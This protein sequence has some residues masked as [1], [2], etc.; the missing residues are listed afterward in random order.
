MKLR[1]VLIAILIVIPIIPSDAHPLDIS[2]TTLQVHPSCLMAT[3]YIHPYEL[4]LLAESQDLSLEK[5]SIPELR[6]VVLAYFNERFVIYSKKG[7]VYKES[8]V[9]EGG[10][11]Y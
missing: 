2:L 7:I 1:G 10:Q 4:T 11:L 3:T 8:L 5:A 6:K 9:F